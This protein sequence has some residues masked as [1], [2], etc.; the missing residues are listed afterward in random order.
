MQSLT[1]VVIQFNENESPNLRLFHVLPA[2]LDAAVRTLECTRVPE[3]LLRAEEAVHYS[4]CVPGRVVCL[5]TVNIYPHGR[6]LRY[7]WARVR[8]LTSDPAAFMRNAAG[9][10]APGS[11]RMSV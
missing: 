11:R 2:G 7:V 10:E 5:C 1:H 9:G 8:L 6:W 3:Q 4:A